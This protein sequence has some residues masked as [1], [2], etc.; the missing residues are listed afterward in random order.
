MIN[1]YFETKFNFSGKNHIKIWIKNIIESNR[2]VVGNINYIFVD[3]EQLLKINN[4]FLS[5]DYFTDII[6]FNFCKD[7]IINSDIYI[8]IERIKENSHIFKTTFKEEFLRVI[9]HGILHL[10]GFND[11]T[12]EE[13]KSMRQQENNLL[14][15]IDQSKI[16]L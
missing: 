14:L 11:S 5:H 15:K 16:K 4:Q 13:Q 10:L 1:F 8:S 9:I 3:D 12:K 2:L 6:T 7:G